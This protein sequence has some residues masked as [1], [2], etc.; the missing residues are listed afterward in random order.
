M[1]TGKTNILWAKHLYSNP[2]L[3]NVK[4]NDSWET[5]SSLELEE[6]KEDRMKMSPSAQILAVK[7]GKLMIYLRGYLIMI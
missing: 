7:C 2:P 3:C 5:A 1:R 4:T 6:R